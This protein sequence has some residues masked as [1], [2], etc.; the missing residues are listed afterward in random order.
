ML[1]KICNTYVVFLKRCKDIDFFNTLFSLGHF[2]SK[3]ICF[4]ILFF[5][6]DVF[7]YGNMGEY[8]YI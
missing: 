6:K 4:K 8:S 1:F 3:K 7:G 2:F 5:I